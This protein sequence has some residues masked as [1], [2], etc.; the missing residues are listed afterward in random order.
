M[1]GRFVA[2]AALTLACSAMAQDPLKSSDC[3]QAL[4]Q[5]DI[6]REAKAATVEPLRRAAAAQCLGG[7]DAPSRPSRAAQAPIRVP[8][9]TIEV[10]PRVAPPSA[11]PP[12][13]P[14]AIDRPPTVSSCDAAGCWVSRGDRLQYVTP[15]MMG[16]AGFCGV[17]PGAPG[18]P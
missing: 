5:L 4:A 1:P 15:G 16:P 2:I 3:A 8:P 6:A 13:P 17:A 11:A 18:C 10:R 7:P 14:L 12:L 9:P